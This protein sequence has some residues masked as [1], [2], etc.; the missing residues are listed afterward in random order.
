MQGDQSDYTEF[1]F[2]PLTFSGL[3]CA[4]ISCLASF[5]V[6]VL[7]IYSKFYKKQVGLVVL[8]INFTDFIFCGFKI[9]NVF[10]PHRS[11]ATC[12]FVQAVSGYGLVSS[13]ISSV[14]FGY[15]LYIMLKI[16]SSE[17][18]ARIF[19]IYIGIALLVPA[20]EV[21]GVLLADFVVYSEQ[22]D[23]CVHRVH[24]RS[25]DY[26][27]IFLRDIPFGL[28]CF[29]SIVCYVRIVWTI[30]SVVRHARNSD[31][32]AFMAYPGIVICCWL[33]NLV[34]NALTEFGVEI[35]HTVITFFLMFG[36]LQG[37]WDA[38][39]YGTS[40]NIRMFCS[41]RCKKRSE[42]EDENMGQSLTKY[43]SEDNAEGTH[44][45]FE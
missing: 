24:K 39:A 31:L 40:K 27:F 25:V 33:P 32:L 45:N 14:L 4:I 9:L 37:L 10:I 5:I 3:S 35:N 36:Q 8:W 12:A 11:N 43:S 2:F 34:N 23:T 21:I 28:F 22:L 15:V 42:V 20:V 38:I 6:S 30:K 41:Q 18:P 26:S 17:I 29:L 1:V 7:C 44:I 13:V 16:R 19:N